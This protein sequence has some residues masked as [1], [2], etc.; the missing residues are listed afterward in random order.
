MDLTLS[1]EKVQQGVSVSVVHLNATVSELRRL[2]LV[3]DLI[4]SIKFG[5]LL[6]CLTHLGAW[7]NGMTL[8]IIGKFFC[9][10]NFGVIFFNFRFFLLF[11]SIRRI[12]H[13]T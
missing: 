11:C 4:D 5:L 10:L 2:F 1:Q 13:L 3:E 9:F 8:V 7:F 6:W 12:V